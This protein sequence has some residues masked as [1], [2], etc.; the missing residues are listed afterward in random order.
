METQQCIFFLLLKFHVVFNSVITTE[1]FEVEAQQYV[2]CIV[3]LHVSL[4]TVRN[5][6]SSLCKLPDIAVRF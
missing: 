6:V 4:P 2:I 5:T 3:A 1:R